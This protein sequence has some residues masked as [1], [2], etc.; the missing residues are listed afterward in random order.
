MQTIDIPSIIIPKITI[1][2]LDVGDSNNYAGRNLLLNSGIKYEN[3]KYQVA[4]YKITKWSLLQYRTK[5]TISVIADIP[6]NYELWCYTDEGHRYIIPMTT[7]NSELGMYIS[8]TYWNIENYDFPNIHGFILYVKP[9]DSNRP[10]S[11]IHKC[12]LELGWND[13]P[14]WTPAPEDTLPPTE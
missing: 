13:Y 11:I 5:I 12:K 14:V 8:Q 3:N 2:E 10:N 4:Y 7:Y 1:P 6:N 9:N